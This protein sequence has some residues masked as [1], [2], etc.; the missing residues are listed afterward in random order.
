MK[1]NK[2]KY[3]LIILVSVFA[4]ACKSYD[5]DISSNFSDN[6]I[7]GNWADTVQF[8][9]QGYVVY[10]LV[11][12]PNGS[13]EVNNDKYGLYTD[14]AKDSISAFRHDLGNYVLSTK[15]IYFVSNQS[16]S[17]D[18]MTNKLPQTSVKE[19]TLFQSCT[20]KIEKN[21]LELNYIETQNKEEKQV[22]HTYKKVRDIL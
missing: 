11:F 10:S 6:E 14:Q 22:T 18:L 3:Y 19:S 4:I 16:I 13:F 20:Y 7:F 8:Q 5:E 17:W 21:I 1:K 2:L 15:N 9:P 12:R